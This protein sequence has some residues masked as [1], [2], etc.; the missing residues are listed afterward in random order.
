MI[1]DV[2]VVPVSA[3]RPLGRAI[4]HSVLAV[5]ATC[6]L[7][8]L[9]GT[10]PAGSAQAAGARTVVVD[11]G[12]MM[13]PTDGQL[14][15]F[16][17]NT[18]PS[19][20]PVA[21]L[22]PGTIRID[23]GLGDLSAGPDRLD[24]AKLLARVA[25]VR[26]KGAEPIVILS[27]MPTWLGKAV[28]LGR[29]PARVAP[30]NLDVWQNL[31]RQVV[32]GVATAPAPAYQFEVWNEPDLPVFWQDTPSAFLDM[33]ARTHRAVQAVAHETGLPLRVGGPAAFIP[34]PVFIAAYLARMRLEGLPVDFVSWHYYGNYPFIG[35]NGAENTIP[36]ALLPFYPVI[37]QQ[38]PV[39]TPSLFGAQVQFVRQV[40]D[41]ATAGSNLHPA[42]TI[43]EW[44]LS[45]GGRDLRHDTHEGAAFAAGVLIEL[46]RAGL[47]AS[48]FYRALGDG[49]PGD[50]SAAGPHGPKPVWW[51]FDVWTKTAG[52][53]VAGSAHDPAD[54]LW[55]RAST[56]GTVADVLLVNFKAKAGANRAL[57]VQ[58]KH[59]CGTAELRKIDAT[60]SSFDHAEAAVSHGG[61]LELT[62]AAQSVTWI[63]VPVACAAVAG[64]GVGAARTQAVSQPPRL[65]DTGRGAGLP[66]PALLVAAAIAALGAT[67]AAGRRRSSPS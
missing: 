14:V 15:G 20:D 13:G 10:A 57:D 42:L 12:A 52:R 56:S 28:A 5:P 65:A 54:G 4:R 40:V 24:L 61:I 59:S 45:A 49:A 44:N 51:V 11:P 1:R 6:A 48:D 53:L 67:G 63:R 58:V 23:A 32:H 9:L 7:L 3:G 37:G 62:L 18:G 39:S 21:S 26:A 31:I 66:L 29:D 22:H 27:Y 55:A 36:A 17:W 2:A 38:N 50:W 60:S 41:A 46:E 19:L 30:S 34:D 8:A 47:G 43:D 25:E 33:A 35:P 16:D 64:K